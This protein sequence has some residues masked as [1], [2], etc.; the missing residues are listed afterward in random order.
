MILCNDF[1]SFKTMSTE[2]T[3]WSVVRICT[4]NESSPKIHFLRL[5]KEGSSMDIFNEVR[6]DVETFEKF[7]KR[8][9]HL[10][11]DWDWMFDH[12]CP[13]LGH[14]ILA[15]LHTLDSCHYRWKAWQVSVDQKEGGAAESSFHALVHLNYEPFK[16]NDVKPSIRY[17]LFQLSNKHKIVDQAK[18]KICDFIGYNQKDGP[19]TIELCNDIFWWDEL[20]ILLVAKLDCAG[21]T[22]RNEWYTGKVSVFA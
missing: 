12:T 20:N 8:Q 2:L 6:K 17:H 4:S 1:A 19:F 14:R 21:T 18:Q 16:Q 7:T 13:P 22:R 9:V 3:F 10:D 15:D 5:F 11:D